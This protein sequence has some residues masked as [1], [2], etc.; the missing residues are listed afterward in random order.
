MRDCWRQPL[1]CFSFLFC[2]IFLFVFVA[3]VFKNSQ[4]HMHL[5]LNY[6]HI[7]LHLIFDSVASGP[8]A[9]IQARV[10]RAPRRRCACLCSPRLVWRLTSWKPV[11]LRFESKTNRVHG[12]IYEVQ[13]TFATTTKKAENP[14]CYVNRHLLQL[15]EL[16]FLSSNPETCS[17]ICLH[18]YLYLYSYN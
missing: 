12:L 7:F 13:F 17:K 8:G 18:K 15:A 6:T 11:D 9:L 2:V 16:L 4:L 1:V 10:F 5:S 3:Y 14:H